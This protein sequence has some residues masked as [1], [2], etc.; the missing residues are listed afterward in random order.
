VND[1]ESG[2]TDLVGD[3]SVDLVG[4]V[5]SVGRRHGVLLAAQ[6]LVLGVKGLDRAFGTA[7]SEP[8]DGHGC[9]EGHPE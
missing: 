5:Q 4:S 6:N 3:V 9:Q 7:V 2:P 8:S 1:S